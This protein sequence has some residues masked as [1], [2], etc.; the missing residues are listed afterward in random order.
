[1]F[2][3]RRLLVLILKVVSRILLVLIR[4][5][6][7]FSSDP[8]RPDPPLDPLLLTPATV[9][10]ERIRRG[11]L[12]SSALV[13][14]F[15]SRI[16]Q[17]NPSLNAVVCERFEEALQEAR[18]VD[19]LVSGT[20]DEVMLKVKYPLLG[21][22]FTVKEA[23][24]LQGMRQ[25]SGLL[26]R[27]LMHSQ[28][29]AVVV[30]RLKRAG[31]IPLGVT[32]C[33]ELC[34]WYESSNKVYGKTRNPYN[35][36]HIVGG[37]S[38]G[39]GCILAAGGSVIGVGSD[40]GGSIRMP[41]FFNGIYGHKPTAGIVPNDGQFP[42]AHGRRSEFLCTGPMCRYA[43]D[44][45]TV[46]K[47]MAGE[48]TSRL[49]LDQDVSLTSLRFFSMENDGGSPFISPVDKELVEA[50]RRVVKHLE[51][52][53]GVSVQPVTIYNL[54]Y[55][56]QIWS[57]MMSSD[58]DMGQSFAD[59]MGDGKKIWPLW[60][61]VKWMFGLSEHTLPA[62]GL[63]LTEKLAH[64][65]PQGNER[66]IQK[67]K[68]LREEICTL[69]GEDGILI[70]PSHPKTAP[71]HHEPLA[72]PFNFA[73]TG[74]FNVLGLPVT[75]CPL[76]LSQAGLPMGIQ[77]IAS[78]YNDHLTLALAQHLEKALGGWIPAESKLLTSAG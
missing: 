30:S 2:V 16:R 76:S 25:S 72:M 78:H 9:L 11:E 60:E 12:K 69:L 3:F 36:K 49:S 75:Q 27:Q 8:A 19:N 44:L 74:I 71:R 14:S 63:A 42:D 64:L 15:I 54:R 32:N 4:I 24:A 48:A 45:I 39:E 57:A 18:N 21:V 13:Q 58:G 26:S 5:F 34:M 22:P 68:H 70:Y 50:Q 67:A 1:M 37:S 43:T 17:V 6:S 38:G 73:Y 59:L 7:V 61:L 52:E 31:G 10:A 33:S 51:K 62:I 23:F 77:L 40:I 46:L 41:A 55:S 29:D 53:L 35:P 20:E 66:M 65:N 47:V 56:F 28:T